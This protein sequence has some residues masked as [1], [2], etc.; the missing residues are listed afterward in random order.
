ML[1]YKNV[2]FTSTVIVSRG[3]LVVFTPVP[4]AGGPGFDSRRCK[5]PLHFSS[6]FFYRNIC[7]LRNNNP[8]VDFLLISIHPPLFLYIIRLLWLD[9]RFFMP[10]ISDKSSILACFTTPRISRALGFTCPLASAGRTRGSTQYTM[11]ILVRFSRLFYL[12]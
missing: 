9:S 12:L 5:V 1:S 3:S 4:H 6:S 10:L 11:V 2:L 7:C 8:L